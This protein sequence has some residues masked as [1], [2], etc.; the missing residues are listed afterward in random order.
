M[1]TLAL[2]VRD[3]RTLAACRDADPEI[4]FPLATAGT[5]AEKRQTALALAYC[6]ACPVR[7]ECLADAL[8]SDIKWGVW[9]GTTEADREAL[10]R[11]PV[12]KAQAA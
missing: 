2:A 6:G 1:T 10:G 5:D 11:N 9:G 4:F 7:P 12:A 3:W 8:G